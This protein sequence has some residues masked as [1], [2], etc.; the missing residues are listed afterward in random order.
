V[1]GASTQEQA[2]ENIDTPEHLE[3]AQVDVVQTPHETDFEGHVEEQGSTPVEEEPPQEDA[4]DAYEQPKD[5]EMSEITRDLDVF[6]PSGED[7]SDVDETEPAA[8][9]LHDD[10]TLTE[11]SLQLDIE[12]EMEQESETSQTVEV[13]TDGQ[14]EEM[15]DTVDVISSNGSGPEEGIV[16]NLG[17][18][19]GDEHSASDARP[20]EESADGTLDIA[21]GL[22]LTPSLSAK[23]EMPEEDIPDS[24]SPLEANLDDATGMIEMDDDTAI[25]KD[26]LTRAAASKANKPTVIARRESLQNRRD[27][28]VIRQALASPRKILE[29]KDPNSPSKYDNDATL[30]LTQTLT[31]NMDQQFPASPTPGHQQGDTDEPMDDQPTKNSRRSSRARK[32]K[33]PAPSSAASQV[34]I[35]KNISVRRADGSEPI[36]LKKTEAQ[37]LGLLTRANTRKNKQGAM[38][39]NV[40]LLKLKM[41]TRDDTL[42]SSLEAIAGK[43]NVHWDE[44][45]AY[46]QEGTDTVANM[47]ADAASLAS[48]D[49]LSVQVVTPSSKKKGKETKDSKNETPRKVKRVRGL[50][51]ANGTP[52]KGLLAPASMLPDGLTD[53]DDAPPVPVEK[54]VRK[55]SKLKKLVIAPTS[56]ESILASPARKGHIPPS[57]RKAAAAL[58]PL[59]IAPMGIESVKDIKATKERK[60]RLATPKRVKLPQPTS[61]VPSLPVPV[62]GKENQANLGIRGASPKKGVKLSEA[63][64]PPPISE[65]GLPR[66]RAGRRL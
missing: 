5:H 23:E 50:G 52:G 29:D 39:V 17:H 30:D 45:L 42:S 57:P 13:L 7:D 26:F 66:R 41:E 19:E 43:K 8:E 37:E 59:E 12:R 16:E 60:S 54:S 10:F 46:Y 38:A 58:P 34:P 47:M 15:F 22:T 33:L 51:A 25:L 55:A 14:E 4:T 3:E 61:A 24:E 64:L 1:T 65:S 36:V 53:E 56:G 49:E 28:G 35:P 32:S 44:T 21:D 2:S 63:V 11:V 6:A 31:L 18:D 9:P 20:Q 27:S 48:P 40:R 62:G